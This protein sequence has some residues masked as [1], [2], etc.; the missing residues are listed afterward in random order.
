MAE[1]VAPGSWA[2]IRIVS[3]VSV[4]H[5]RRRSTTSIT[6]DPICLTVLDAVVKDTKSHAVGCFGKAPQPQSQTDADELLE[7][8]NP[9]Q[10]A[11]TDFL[12]M[13]TQGA[14]TH[15][16]IDRDGPGTMYGF[17]QVATLRSVTGLENE[18]ALLVAGNLA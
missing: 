8:F 2:S 18:L 11:I 3:F 10:N 15:M 9:F 5:D 13:T 4:G 12:M 14:H 7:D 6:S 16:S 1:I 17:Q